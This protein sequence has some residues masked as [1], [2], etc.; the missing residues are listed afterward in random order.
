ME[1]GVNT[2]DSSLAPIAQLAEAA[3]LKSVQCRFESDWGH[4]KSA[5][6]LAAGGLPYSSLNTVTLP[7]RISEAVDEFLGFCA[8]F[9]KLALSLG[10][11]FLGILLLHR[12][13]VRRPY[14]RRA[15]YWES[16]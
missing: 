5:G 13:M 7:R 11:A 14:R 10:D 2:L 6:P 8:G 4:P 16:L 9:S 3:D 1:S 12:Q 15:T